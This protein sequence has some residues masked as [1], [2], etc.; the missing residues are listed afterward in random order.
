MIRPTGAVV[1]G[2][3]D[4]PHRPV[5]FFRF[6]RLNRRITDDPPYRC[7]GLGL[8]SPASRGCGPDAG[9]GRDAD[10]AWGEGVE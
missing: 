9:R 2:R 7:C 10:V 6:E 1:C 5:E 4:G 3:A 8:G